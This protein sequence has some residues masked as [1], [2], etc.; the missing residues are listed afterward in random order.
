MNFFYRAI[1]IE[2]L[3]GILPKKNKHLELF[4]SGF[5]QVEVSNSIAEA[6]RKYINQF[7]KSH[8]V[9]IADAIIAATAKEA[10]TSLYTLN[11]KH[12][13][14]TDKPQGTVIIKQRQGCVSSIHL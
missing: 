5:E 9:N 13:P 3:S 7:R 14:M 1:K 8:G 4:L 6:D 12:Y 2:L 11:I 10:E